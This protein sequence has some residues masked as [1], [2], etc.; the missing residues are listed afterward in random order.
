M[1]GKKLRRK[2]S[3]ASMAFTGFSIN[4]D[5]MVYPVCNAIDFHLRGGSMNLWFKSKK[6]LERVIDKKDV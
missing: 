6:L 1:K 4:D 3:I 2:L 5:L